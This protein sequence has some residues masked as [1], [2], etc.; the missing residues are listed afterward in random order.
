M[1]TKL[2]KL[3]KEEIG[4]GGSVVAREDINLQPARRMGRRIHRLS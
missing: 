3:G 2:N 1:V 4:G